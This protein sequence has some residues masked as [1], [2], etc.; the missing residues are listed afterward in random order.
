L[1]TYRWFPTYQQF[2]NIQMNCKFRVG[3]IY[4]RV[5]KPDKEY[6]CPNPPSKNHNVT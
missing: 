3:P 4:G 5:T 2:H 1:K 6:F